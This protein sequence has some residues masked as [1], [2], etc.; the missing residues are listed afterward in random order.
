MEQISAFSQAEIFSPE[1]RSYGMHTELGSALHLA[2]Q[3]CRVS[4][5]ICILQIFLLMMR[6]EHH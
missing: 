4:G 3:E 1:L 5:L 2:C 6:A